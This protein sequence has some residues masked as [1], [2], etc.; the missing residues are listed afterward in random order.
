[1][2][3][4]ENPI[5]GPNHWSWE[6]G[7]AEQDH[8]G[9]YRSLREGVYLC[10][11]CGCEVSCLDRYQVSKAKKTIRPLCAVC[12]VKLLSAAGDE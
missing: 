5:S 2:A 8:D 6:W 7:P 1:M 9:A 4:L 11:K 12:F 10:R 3:I